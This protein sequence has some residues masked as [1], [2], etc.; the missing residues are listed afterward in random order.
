MVAYNPC[1][2]HRRTIALATSQH[3]GVAWSATVTIDEGPGEYSYPAIIQKMSDGLVHL[4]YTWR[5]QRILR[6]LS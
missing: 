2:E 1:A 4:T 6:M 5:R 3:N